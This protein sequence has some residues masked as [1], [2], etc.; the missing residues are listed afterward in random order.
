V[1]LHDRLFGHRQDA[2]DANDSGPFIEPRLYTTDITV[3]RM[4]VLLQARPQGM[5]LLTDELAGW[6]HNMHRYSGGD[7]TQGSWHG[8]A[9]P[10]PW[11]A[12]ADHRSNSPACSWAW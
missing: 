7:D 4:A 1:D 6:L 5:L 10:I 11:N 9:N 8:T 3:E 2:P 12:W